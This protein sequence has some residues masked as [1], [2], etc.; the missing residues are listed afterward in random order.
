MWRNIQFQLGVL[1]VVPISLIRHWILPLII[2]ANVFG[3]ISFLLILQRS[4]SKPIH[5]ISSLYISFKV[6]DRYVPSLPQSH[7]LDFTI[8]CYWVIWNWTLLVF[9]YV[10]VIADQHYHNFWTHKD[11][12]IFKI[13]LIL[14]AKMRKKSEIYFFL[15]FR[16]SVWWMGWCDTCVRNFWKSSF[17]SSK[18]FFWSS[19]LFFSSVCS[20]FCWSYLV[21]S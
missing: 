9:A 4:I 8:P 1:F 17:S 15:P 16:V 3:A 5:C 10:K 21:Y 7:V 14:I 13:L 19:Y 20:L 2:I 12:I 11:L 18:A 6:C